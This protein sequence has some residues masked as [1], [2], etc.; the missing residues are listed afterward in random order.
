MRSYLKL[1]TLS[2]ENGLVYRASLLIWRFRQ[3]LSTVMA[4]TVWTVIMVD[5]PGVFGYTPA[6]MTSYVL[7]VSLL[8]S[9]ILASAWHGLAGEV[10]SG[11]ISKYLLKPMH[12]LGYIAAVELADKARNFL[13]SLVEA[14]LLWF[15]LQPAILVPSWDRILLTIA[16][17]VLG[18]FINFAITILFG[19][20]G[21]Y[22]PE[23]WGPKFLFFMIV[24][25]TAGKLF[26]LDILPRVIQQVLWLTPFPFLSYAQTQLYL[27]RVSQDQFL[28][29]TLVILAWAIGLWVIAI[30][31]WRAGVTSYEANG[32]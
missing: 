25:V 21:F 27:G 5:K 31:R 20:L 11:N 1:F 18:T 10:Y 16:W 28:S 19:T 29:L 4:L 30:Q 26:P 7:L 24:D 12:P 2:W 23:T 8:Q 13:C 32:Q 9:L 3:L 15:I 14:G 17:T 6:Q 22:S